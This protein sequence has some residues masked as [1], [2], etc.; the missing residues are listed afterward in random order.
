M[1]TFP[2]L[3][4]QPAS[5]Q[6][7]KNR[8]EHVKKIIVNHPKY[9]DIYDRIQET[10]LLSVAAGQP[11]GVFL[12][13]LTGVGKT[14]LLKDYESTHPRKRINGKTIVPIFYFKVPVGAT[15]KSFASQALYHLGDP[16]FERGTLVQMTA[17]L[18]K[19]VKACN[20]EMMVI[21]EFQHLID[22]DSSN[23]L[24]NASDWIKT[25]IEDAKIPV[26]ICGMPES[27]SI[28]EVNNQ[29]DRRFCTRLTLES[30]NYSTKEEQIEFRAF[31]NTVDKQLPVAEQSF[32]A[33][34][35]LSEKFYYATNG[36]PFYI[37]R[38]IEQATIIA[39]KHGLDKISESELFLAY[40]AV[41]IS[42]RPN[43]KNPFKNPS[44]NLFDA[45]DEEKRA[46]NRHG[47]NKINK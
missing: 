43:A 21:D 10:H 32:L 18:L 3:N 28:F 29:L 11:D 2:K 45:I 16:N 26:L 31:L 27:K 39:A 25:F 5:L 40:K 6:D 24:K 22:K 34:P 14:T 8:K 46:N 19:L 35:G 1:N 23:V 30:F 36:V 38:I 33:D 12:A 47:K 4:G 44:F 17:R 42:Q 9:K 13:G 41:T 15:P 7:I 20:V 37:M